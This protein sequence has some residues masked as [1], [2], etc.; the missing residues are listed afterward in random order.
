MSSSRERIIE[1]AFDL[2][3]EHG[4]SAV[5]TSDIAKRAGVNQVTLFRQFKG[6]ACIAH[7]VMEEKVD[8]HRAKEIASAMM[9]S[10]DIESCAKLASSYYAHA[11]SS[12][13]V[14]LQMVLALE[15][16]KAQRYRLAHIR[17][18]FMKVIDRERSKKKLRPIDTVN[19]ERALSF[20]LYGF[21]IVKA[22]QID[23]IQQPTLDDV[24]GFCD[25]WL[26][27]VLQNSK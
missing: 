5:S 16:P 22:F 8:Q 20:L 3:S 18:A 19:A 26:K 27:G 23:P 24:P 10:P 13:F 1:A 17:R 21:A 7:A 15:L 9:R 6:K 11:L 25:I 14:R 4:Y 2:F 12:K